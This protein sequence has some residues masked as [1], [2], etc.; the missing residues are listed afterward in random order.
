VGEMTGWVT[1]KRWWSS[2]GNSKMSYIFQSQGYESGW[3]GYTIKYG[4]EIESPRKDCYGTA[5]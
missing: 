3:T 2:S 1:M 5:D 4:K